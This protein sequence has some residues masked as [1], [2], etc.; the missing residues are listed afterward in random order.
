MTE[1]NASHWRTGKTS[2]QLKGPVTLI[3]IISGH[4]VEAASCGLCGG[5]GARVRCAECGR[6]ALCA[7]CD[8]MYH[9]H[10]KRR[11]HQRQVG[12]N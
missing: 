11:N 9:R 1:I 12:T 7:S 8:D 3:L 5:G 6:R 10:P 2:D 4:P